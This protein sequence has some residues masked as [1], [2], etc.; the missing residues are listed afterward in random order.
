[1]PGSM[2][3]EREPVMTR[4]TGVMVVSQASRW[5][6]GER[7]GIQPTPLGT[8]VVFHCEPLMAFEGGRPDLGG[9]QAA[10]RQRE[11]SRLNAQEPGVFRAGM[12]AVIFSLISRVSPK[13]RISF[14]DCVPIA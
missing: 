14:A 12:P 9:D 7:P 2:R 1:M 11:W 5:G 4:E 6:M 10:P 3:A 13:L 8:P